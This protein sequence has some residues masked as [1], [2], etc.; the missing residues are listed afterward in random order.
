MRVISDGERLIGVQA[1]SKENLKGMMDMC[2]LAIRKKMT[3]KEFYGIERSYAPP[4]GLL[5]DALT[6]A[7]EQLL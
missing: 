3:I 6:N 4:A 1:M 2:A 7:T 5:T